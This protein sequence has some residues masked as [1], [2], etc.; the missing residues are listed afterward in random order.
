[1]ATVLWTPVPSPISTMA[2]TSTGN[3]WVVASPKA[4]T[5]STSAPAVMTRTVPTRS[6]RAPEG[7]CIPA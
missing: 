5:P 2:A 3:A 1:M 6:A 7:N 4:A